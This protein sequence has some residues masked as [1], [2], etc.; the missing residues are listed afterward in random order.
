MQ[1]RIQASY[2]FLAITSVAVLLYLLFIPADPVSHGRVYKAWWDF[3]HM[4]SFAI[5]TYLLLYG[6]AY[7]RSGRSFA[8]IVI[9]ALV[10]PGVEMVQQRLGR[11]FSWIDMVH[12]WAGVIAAWFLY[13]AFQSR[14]RGRWVLPV[15][16]ITGFSLCWPVRII[17][18]RKLVHDAHPVLSGF[19]TKWVPSRWIVNGLDIVTTDGGWEALCRGD[20]GYPGLFLADMPEDWRNVQAVVLDLELKT[21]SASVTLFWRM[22]D[23]PGDPS[24]G[25]RCEVSKTVTSGRQTIRITA[26]EFSRAN[27][28]RPMNL[29]HIHVAGFFFAGLSPKDRLVL[30]RLAL[31]EDTMRVDVPSR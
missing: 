27:N 30:H 12:G 4:P 2:R 29:H 28:G 11:E 31:E 22:D 6:I 23:L 17:W 1:A 5:V 14:H 16:L 24:Y 9:M 15:F 19:D 10:V 3:M 25:N 8:V 18:D 7:G 13:S 26:S 20:H 21:T